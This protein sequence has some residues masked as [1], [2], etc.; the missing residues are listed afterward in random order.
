[1]DREQ[2]S[3][4]SIAKR[5]MIIEKRNAGATP[6]YNLINA[7]GTICRQWIGNPRHSAIE[8]AVERRLDELK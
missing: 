8:K 1:M 7:D 3:W 2:L 5:E 6:A 4:R